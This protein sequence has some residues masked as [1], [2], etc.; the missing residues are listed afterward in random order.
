MENFD[1]QKLIKDYLKGDQKALENL[2]RFYL[3]PVYNFVL[4]YVN[5]PKD[6]EDITQETFVRMWRNLKKYKSQKASFKTWL[7]TIAKNAAIDFLRQKKTVPLDE[8]AETLVD[9][10]SLTLELAEQKETAQNIKANLANLSDK[11]RQIFL[12]HQEQGFTFKQISQKLGESINTIKSRYRR[13]M[14]I[15]KKFL[16]AK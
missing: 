4:I 2:I 1:E 6:A 9:P 11:Y 12:L 10:V 13:A 8:V 14:I 15:L 5:N 3:K 7:F 16:V